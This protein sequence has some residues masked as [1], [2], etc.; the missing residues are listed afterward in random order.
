M[1]FATKKEKTFKCQEVYV[2]HNRGFQCVITEAHAITGNHKI[3]VH[4]GSGEAKT[5]RWTTTP[6]ACTML[7]DENHHND[8]KDVLEISNVCNSTMTALDHYEVHLRDYLYILR[9]RRK[10]IL[11]FCVFVL[12]VF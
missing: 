2:I 1:S 3:V 5:F 6:R 10:I 8:E 12:V 11:L 4:D 7:P 9:K